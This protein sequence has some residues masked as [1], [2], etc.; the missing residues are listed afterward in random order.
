M[1]KGSNVSLA[2]GGGIHAGLGAVLRMVLRAAFLILNIVEGSAPFVEILIIANLNL[3]M[4]NRA[5]VAK[6]RS[7]VAVVGHLKSLATV[8]SSEDLLVAILVVAH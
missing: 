6:L 8:L 4:M 1:D 3:R 7:L 2:L 5:L